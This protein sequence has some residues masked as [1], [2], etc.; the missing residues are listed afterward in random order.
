MDNKKPR[1]Q[2]SGRL[3]FVLATAGS[4][5]GLGNIMKFPWMTGQNGGA[6]FLFVYI[7]VMLII[8]I[9]ML[10]AASIH[11]A[12]IAIL[13]PLIGSILPSGQNGLLL[14]FAVFAPAALYRG[15][16]NMYGMGAG[17][18]AILTGLSFVPPLAL[19]GMFIAV[20]YLQ[21][22]ADPTNSHNTWISG[23]TGVDTGIILKRI[24]PYAWVMCLLMLAYVWL[25]Q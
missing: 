1:E 5:V 7:V 10:I 12:S 13:Q 21:G 3:G 17:I 9:G 22:L 24:L 6:A 11:P 2:W 8:G 19:C 23:Y 18:A 25:T 15:P 20:G 16:L 4:A 14:F